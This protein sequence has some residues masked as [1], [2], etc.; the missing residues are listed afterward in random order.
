ME[1][2][3]F[4]SYFCINNISNGLILYYRWKFKEKPNEDTVNNLA[5]ATKIPK[6]LARVLVGRGINT[7]ED[8]ERFFN[9]SKSNIHDPFLLR[10]MDV[11]TE[12]IISALK[13]GEG[14]WI[15]G[16]YDVDGTTSTAALLKC[17]K[18][19][20]GNVDFFI[21]DRFQDG[22][23]LSKKSVDLARRKKYKI[24][25]T[26][27]VGVTAIEISK[28][29]KEKNLD[30]IICDHHE[31]SNE[32]P[33]ALAILDPILEGETYPFK[34]LAACGVV[35]K[36]IQGIC[37]KMGEPEEAYKFL[38]FV[39]LASAADMVPLIGENR[40]LVYF[41]LKQFNENTRPGLKGLIHCTNLKPGSIT[42]S[43]IVF[44]VAPIINAAGRM[45]DAIRSVEMM[46][47]DDEIQAFQIAQQLEDENRRR[48]VFDLQTF[49]EAIPIATEQL[50][51][52]ARC[53]VIHNP[54]W[55]AGVIGIV[56]SRLV[57]KFNVPTILMTTINGLAKGSC[58]STSD[59]DIH[60]A[61]K[62]S[63]HL[64]IEFGGHRHAA[65]LSLKEENIPE[66]REI[67]QGLTKKTISS[68][69]M[70]REIEI[71]S[72]LKL[73][74]LSPNFLNAL[75]KFAPYGYSNYK[76]I[77]F[78]RGVKS[79]NGVRIVGQNNLKF[80]VIQNNFVIDAIAYGLANRFD[81]VSSGKPFNI[82]YN[83]EINNFNGQN[84][85]QL[86]IKDIKAQK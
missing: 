55:H 40:T 43:N 3:S 57:E 25:I 61:L 73:N 62:K 8:A 15:H 53:L 56:A 29:I 66:L 31:P 14:I 24:I 22:Y 38:D 46:I 60:G 23:G 48:R 5:K 65:G 13:N 26:V 12:R 76:P 30:L 49:E 20:G 34:S 67:V 63:A 32:L 82:L 21:P 19:Y 1:K 69:M 33:E 58:R 2:G 79:S 42:A 77:F 27:D 51:K 84:S 45:G 10:D 80:R 17:L 72:E 11:A 7:P 16:D 44:A 47:Q 74:E 59:F 83:L 28:Y 35:F 86:Y 4:F 9:P 36:L 54:N 18:H 6:T 85:P 70:T 50:K 64:L 39:A 41:G 68:D 75:N 81:I 52:G 71:D 78:S 37:T